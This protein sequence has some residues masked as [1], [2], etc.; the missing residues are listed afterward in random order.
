[1]K[2]K[3]RFFTSKMYKRRLKKKIEN[4]KCSQ[5]YQIDQNT[6]VSDLVFRTRDPKVGTSRHRNEK[7][8][9]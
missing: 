6:V 2:F 7:F 8:Y 9:K 3:N 5:V 1:M 4:D